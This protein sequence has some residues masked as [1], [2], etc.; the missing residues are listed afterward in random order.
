MGDGFDFEVT[1][2]EGRAGADHPDPL[3]AE[4]HRLMRPERSVVLLASKVLN[5][6]AVGHLMRR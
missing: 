5:P 1:K 4:I 3:A 6:R 2:H